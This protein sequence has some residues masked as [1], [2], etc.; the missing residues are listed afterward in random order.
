MRF[1]GMISDKRDRST[2]REI[3]NFTQRR[4]EGARPNGFRIFE[5]TAHGPVF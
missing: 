3:Y 4:V 5:S 1:A 2:I